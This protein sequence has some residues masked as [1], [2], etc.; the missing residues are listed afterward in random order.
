MTSPTARIIALVLAAGRSSRSAPHH[1]LLATDA[2]GTPMIAR[3]L[4]ALCASKV[5]RIMV[6]LGHRAADL[7]AAI[8]AHAPYARPLSTTIAADHA[9]GLSASLRAGLHS[10]AGL[11]PEGVLV[12]LGD[13]P[14]LRPDLIDRLVAR[15]RRDNPPVTIPVH[16]GRQGHPVLWDRTTIPRLMTLEGD[17]GGGALIRALGT[18]AATVPADETI[19]E[20]FD[21]PARLE[22]FAASAPPQSG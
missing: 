13:M 19:H 17:R 22:R 4:R 1:K 9:T 21:T 18:Q 7:R 16:A 6:V 12:C 3:T 20:D 5:D 2:T 11:S 14:N 15:H 8:D 10:I